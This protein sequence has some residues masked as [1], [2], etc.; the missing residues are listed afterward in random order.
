[1][2]FID[3]AANEIVTMR[4]RREGDLAIFEFGGSRPMR[5]KLLLLKLD[6]VGDFLIALPALERLRRD[7]AGDHVTLVC[8][9][10]NVDFAKTAG[11]ADEIRPYRFFPEDAASWD[12]EPVEGLDRFRAAAAG[13]FD[14]AIDLRVSE[15]TRFL[16]KHVDAAIKGG[17]GSRTRHPYLDILSPTSFERRETGPASWVAPHELKSLLPVKTPLFHETDFSVGRG[18]LVYGGDVPLPVGRFRATWD[19]RPSALLRRFPGVTFTIDVAR[20][21]GSDIVATRRV[22]WGRPADFRSWASVEFDN[23]DPGAPHEFRLHVR[24]RPL[25]SR[26][27]FF[28]LWIERIDQSETPRVKEADLHVGEQLSLLVQLIEERTRP[29]E[30]AHG[31]PSKAVAGSWPPGAR[32]IVIAPI[33][34]SRLRDWGAE[35]YAG[36]AERLLDTEDCAIALVGAPAQ[37]EQLAAIA[38][39]CPDPNRVVNFAGQTD[40]AQTAAIIRDADLVICNNSGIAHLAATCGTPTLALYSGSHQPREWGPRGAHVRVLMGIVPCSPCGHDKLEECTNDHLCM[41]L[42]TPDAVA[43]EAMSMLPPAPASRR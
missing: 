1:M 16:L 3:M 9:P 33:S 7:F 15:D 14:L 32:R 35:N 34:N 39:R 19:L 26:M 24:G 36:L 17:V 11:V 12:G 42:I 43:S 23:T 10:W 4:Q 13:P 5:R 18:H 37:R 20:N 2:P 29:F 31:L 22:V 40:W 8:G 25:W 41:R 27:R 28:G 30:P 6:H 38:A 21:R